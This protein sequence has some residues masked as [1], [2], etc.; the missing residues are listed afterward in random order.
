MGYRGNPPMTATGI[1]A[2]RGRTIYLEGIS[3]ANITAC[4]AC[5]GNAR[6]ASDREVL[7][8]KHNQA[9]RMKARLLSFGFSLLLQERNMCA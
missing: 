3:E 6:S 1:L 4:Y 5:H 2:A 7:A 9:L 8:A